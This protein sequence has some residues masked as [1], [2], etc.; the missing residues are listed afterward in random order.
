M[1]HKQ[2]NFKDN[3][4]SKNQLSTYNLKENNTYIN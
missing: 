2:T 3:A 4:W 1:K